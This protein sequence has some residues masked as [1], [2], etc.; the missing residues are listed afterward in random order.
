MTLNVDGTLPGFFNLYDSFYLAILDDCDINI[1]IF[2]YTDLFLS[3]KRETSVP[4]P[5]TGS[6][7]TSSF[8]KS[9]VTMSTM[10][11]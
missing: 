11:S 7:T 3:Q 6:L 8:G 10:I 1:S 4:P 5:Q 2:G 9:A